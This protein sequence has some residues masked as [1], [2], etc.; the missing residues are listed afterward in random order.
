MKYSTWPRVAYVFSSSSPNSKKLF[1][2]VCT[3]HSLRTNVIITGTYISH[4][5]INLFWCTVWACLALRD[6][7][8]HSKTLSIW[9]MKPWEFYVICDIFNVDLYSIN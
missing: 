3:V 4:L 6:F 1:E 7:N 8:N 5:D 9:N 2:L